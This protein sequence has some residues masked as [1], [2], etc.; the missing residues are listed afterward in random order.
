MVLCGGVCPGHRQG[1]GSSGIW[2]KSGSVLLVTALLIRSND[3]DT[4]PI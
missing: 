3:P 2:F 4:H 1:S